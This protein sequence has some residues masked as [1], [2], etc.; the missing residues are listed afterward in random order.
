MQQATNTGVYSRI[1]EGINP[2]SIGTKAVLLQL[3]GL[4]RDEP[5]LSLVQ[6]P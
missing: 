2:N 3:D 6:L 4:C 5:T 1:R